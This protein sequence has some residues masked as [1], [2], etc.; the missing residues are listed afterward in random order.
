MSPVTKV[1]VDVGGVP[2]RVWF[3]DSGQGSAGPVTAADETSLAKIAV[4][5]ARTQAALGRAVL[6]WVLGQ[7]LGQRPSDIV[8]DRAPSG[9]PFLPGSDWDFSLSYAD[10][11]VGVAVARG[12]RVGLDLARIR[13]VQAADAVAARMFCAADRAALSVL[14]GAAR[15]ARWFQAWTRLEAVVKARGSGILVPQ[16][17]IGTV[18]YAPLPVPAGYAGSVVVL[19]PP[20]AAHSRAG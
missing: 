7:V 5:S 13:P 18:P 19:A 15:Q 16:G 11:L 14:S 8:L 17:D 3:A 20:S 9:R 1:S 6:R 10:A 2:V 12:V 4:P